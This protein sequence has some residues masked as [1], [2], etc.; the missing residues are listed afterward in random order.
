MKVKDGMT[1]M[2][3]MPHVETKNVIDAMEAAE[4]AGDLKALRWAA[5]FIT[6]LYEQGEAYDSDKFFRAE[7]LFNDAYAAKLKSDPPPESIA[8]IINRVDKSEP[9]TAADAGEAIETVRAYFEENL[10]GKSYKAVIE[11][12]DALRKAVETAGAEE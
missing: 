5:R 9:I 6:W 10:G 1:E 2:A 4:A 8:G 3:G 12:L 7:K 11:N